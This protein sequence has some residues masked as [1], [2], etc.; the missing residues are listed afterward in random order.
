[1]E[2]GALGLQ[3]REVADVARLTHLGCQEGEG[4]A[5]GALAAALFDLAVADFDHGFDRQRGGEEGLGASDPATLLQVLERVEHP[6]HSCAGGE[7][8]RCA[9]DVI[10]R[11]TGRG[12]FGGGDCGDALAHGGRTA[13]NDTHRDV[14]GKGLG[15]QF[16]ALHRC[17]QF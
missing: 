6:P 1:M 9:F 12:D 7:V 10:Q 3:N 14:T 11:G 13:V 5:A 8:T 2:V 15:G 16:C 17:R 4:L